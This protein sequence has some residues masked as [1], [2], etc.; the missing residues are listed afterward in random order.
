MKQ[1]YFTA[2]FLNFHLYAHTQTHTLLVPE[3]KK[4]KMKMEIF[5]TVLNLNQWSLKCNI[6][7]LLLFSC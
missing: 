6:M 4:T 2:L 1:I 3:M 5:F 7:M